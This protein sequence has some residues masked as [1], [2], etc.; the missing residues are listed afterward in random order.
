MSS[1]AVQFRSR[2]PRIAEAAVERARLTVVGRAQVGV[3][4]LVA[5]LESVRNPGSEAPLGR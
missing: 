3:D 5:A 1:P 4:D 2:M